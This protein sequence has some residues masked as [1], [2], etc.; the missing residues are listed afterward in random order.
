MEGGGRTVSRFLA[1]GA[2]DRLFVTTVPVLLGDGV[3]GVRGP[4][5]SSVAG[6]RRTPVRTFHAGADTITELTLREPLA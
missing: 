4:V 3:P 6:L 2:L 5:A 1:A